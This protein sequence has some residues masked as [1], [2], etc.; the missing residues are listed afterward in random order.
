MA[1][2][3]LE[4]GSTN[5]TFREEGFEPCLHNM[6]SRMTRYYISQLYKYHLHILDRKHNSTVC[7]HVAVAIS[8]YKPYATN[9]KSQLLHSKMATPQSSYM[10]PNLHQR[11]VDAIGDDIDSVWFN[12]LNTAKNLKDDHKTN[13][14][15]SFKCNN[16]ECRKSGWTSKVVAI[17][18]RSYLKNGYNALV[19]N[20]RCKS[21]MRLGTLTLD[22]QSYV[23][24]VSYRLKKWAGVE[25]KAP[26]YNQKEG[27]RHR[28]ELCEGCK[29]GNCRH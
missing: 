13:V 6:K 10:F 5:K 8:H 20:Q 28:S 3:L 22:E 18:I 12:E 2:S 15:G 4:V 11:V 24:R 9:A 17:L 26:Y 27:P 19:F 25:V 21:C 29:T 16:K 14:M 1:W 7:E 23:E